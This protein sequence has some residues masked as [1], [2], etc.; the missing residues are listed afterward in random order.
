M[1]EISRDEVAAA[2]KEQRDHT[3]IMAKEARK[4]HDMILGGGID[5]DG[6]EIPE[7]NIGL[8]AEMFESDVDSL[9]EMLKAWGVNGE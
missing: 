1:T 6:L 7:V 4:M 3:Q 9:D 5:G 2:M 8:L